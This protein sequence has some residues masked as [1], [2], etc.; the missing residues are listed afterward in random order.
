MMLSSHKAETEF[1]GE[2][3]PATHEIVYL[4]KRPLYEFCFAIPKNQ[5]IFESNGGP[6]L[7]VYFSGQSQLHALVLRMGEAED[8]FDGLSRLMGDIYA[9]VAKREGQV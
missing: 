3:I 1:S 4:V 2:G 5:A 8:F 7:Q 6:L 9:E